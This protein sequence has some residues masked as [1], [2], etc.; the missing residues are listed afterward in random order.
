MLSRKEGVRTAP[1]LII[2][3]QYILEKIEFTKPFFPLWNLGHE[4]KKLFMIADTTIIKIKH[5]S[6]M[7]LRQR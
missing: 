3:K 6:G 1:L 4:S 2:I 5:F 7:I